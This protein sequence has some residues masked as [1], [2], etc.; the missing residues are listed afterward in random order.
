MLN[1]SHR[2]NNEVPF[3]IFSSGSIFP[4]LRNALEADMNLAKESLY[5]KYIDYQNL[6]KDNYP[7]TNESNSKIKP[8]RSPDSGAF[9]RGAT[10]MVPY[11]TNNQL[12]HYGLP[13]GTVN[14][15]Y[16]RLHPGTVSA[17][18][19]ELSELESITGMFCL[20]IV[21]ALILFFVYWFMNQ[22]SGIFS[23]ITGGS[24]T[25][26][27]RTSNTKCS[28]C[29]TL[30]RTN[31]YLVAAIFIG[32]KYFFDSNPLLPWDADSRLRTEETHS[33]NNTSIA[34]KLSNFQC[35]SLPYQ[36][37][38]LPEPKIQTLTDGRENIK[39]KRRKKK[40]RSQ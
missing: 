31:Y 9:P 39:K 27:G 17:E 4:N 19:Y 38:G 11:R 34:S 13:P 20:V 28:N 6:L 21:I 33:K 14:A 37:F 32:V 24:E 2:R 5:Q 1:H 7:K 10:P 12:I 40:R 15:E 36:L 25:T 22:S 16:Y 29:E 35:G 3:D 8:V 26:L 18:Y 30:T 23:L